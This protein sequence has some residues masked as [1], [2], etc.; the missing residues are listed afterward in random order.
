MIEIR[1]SA[2]NATDALNDLR[3]LSEALLSSTTLPVPPESPA[4]TVVETA[5]AAP[6]TR[7]G[8][9]AETATAKQAEAE[10]PETKAAEPETTSA[11]QN[12]E[13]IEDDTADNPNPEADAAPEIKIT[14]DNARAFAVAYVNDAATDQTERKALFQEVITKFGVGKFSDIPEG[15]LPEAVKFVK[16]KRAEK[17]LPATE[18]AAA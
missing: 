12:V 7:K 11:D 8:K 4:P 1:I 18:P 3:Q 13:S 2:D 6:K 10:Q 15:R 17:N 9:A 14:L 16:D 5:A